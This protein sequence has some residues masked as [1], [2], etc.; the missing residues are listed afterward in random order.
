MR[1]GLESA[2]AQPADRRRHAVA[3]VV[4]CRPRVPVRL[5][6]AGLLGPGRRRGLRLLPGGLPPGPRRPAGG[7][8]EGLG[9]GPVGPRVEPGLPP[10]PRRSPLVGRIDRRA[11]RRGAVR[12]VPPPARP[13][14]APRLD[15]HPGLVAGAVVPT[16]GKRS[17]RGPSRSGA[18]ST[19]PSVPRW[20]WW[21]PWPSAAVA[22]AGCAGQEQ[23]GTPSARV[24]TWVSGAAG[25]AAIGTLRV[26]SAN[27]DQAWPTTRRRPPSR[28]CAP[29]SP[30]TPRPP[31]ATCPH[32]TSSS[33]PISTTPTRR[34]PPPGTTATPGAAGNASLLRRSAAERAA[35]LP[36]LATAL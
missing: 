24:S 19:M 2:L 7:G 3:D 28:R 6:R 27:I 20:C 1:S 12:A 22:L 26:D 5:G 15:R 4:R 10:V 30:T 16:V 11:R 14:V 13:V 23:S 17:I 33:P 36:L 9:P 18:G 25:G 8:L 34:R 35:L 29:C 32:P 21:P 31:S